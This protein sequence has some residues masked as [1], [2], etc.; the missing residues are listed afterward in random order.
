[1]RTK[2]LSIVALAFCAGCFAPKAP[3]TKIVIEETPPVKGRIVIDT[4][5]EV[6]YYPVISACIDRL[7][8]A[9]SEMKVVQSEVIAEENGME[10]G[11]KAFFAQFGVL[12]PEGSS[13]MYIKSVGKLRVRNTMENLDLLEAALRELNSDPAQIEITVR[14]ADVDQRVLDEVGAQLV[15]GKPAGHRYD[16]V[17]FASVPAAALERA[18]A[19]RRDVHLMST[20]RVLTRSGEEAVVK[21]VTEC[22][23]PTDYDVRLEPSSSLCA[24]GRVDRVAT[25]LAVV[26]P[27]SFTMREVGTILDI[28]P[29]LTDDAAL[30]DLKVNVQHVGRPVWNDYGAEPYAPNGGQYPL[31]MKQPFFPVFSSDVVV[32]VLPGETQL[33]GAIGLQDGAEKSDRTQFCFVTVRVLDLHGKPI[34]DASAR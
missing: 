24:S 25:D 34:T 12:W 28:T 13:V 21:S 18:L 20:P 4:A 9:C 31:P 26:E 27:Q 16:Y 33:V 10:R 5:M 23:Y 19:A 3:S 22:I 30:V 7:S 6:R 11:W 15:P 32:S 1:M 29:T 8:S 14:L 17:D 2:L